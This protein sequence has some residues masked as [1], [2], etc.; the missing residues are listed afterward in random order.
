M[1]VKQQAG[2]LAAFGTVA[3]ILL[4]SSGMFGEAFAATRAVHSPA[5]A[6]CATR[7]AR[8]VAA[9]PR[10]ANAA[11]TAAGR[12]VNLTSFIV[13]SVGTPTPT[14]SLPTT[15]TET[16]TSVPSSATPTAPASQSDSPSPS[17]SATSPSPSDS[18]TPTSSP[19][20]SKSP[21]PSTSPTATPTPTPTAKKAKLCVSVEP[22]ASGVRPGQTARYAIWVWTATTAA[23]K[24]SV[25]AVV[26]PLAHV[27]AAKFTVCP[28]VQDKACKIGNL[29][30]GQADELQ[31]T[32]KAAD[33]VT[34]GK[35]VKLT[36]TATGKSA[37]SFH[38]AASVLI[39]KKPQAT[40]TLTPSAPTIPALP[41]PVLPG[42]IAPTLP[43][44]AATNPVNL[45]PTVSPG[46]GTPAPSTGP[47]PIT[48]TRPVNAIPASATVPLNPRL[49]GGQLAGLAVLAGAVVIAIAR[50]SLRAQKPQGS[51]A[52]D[53]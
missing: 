51:K 6:L 22:F 5:S 18:S 50:L 43:G 53:D 24:V 21:S 2:R 29:P 10:R 19:T 16:P 7:P 20:T 48:K 30:V 52:A 31:A 34:V 27:G 35:K 47:T 1:P 25:S 38:A 17:D 33:A 42:G 28:V 12:P 14:P 44:T 40:P 39:T 32:V 41:T 45:F 46:T 11:R 9:T 15:P 49:I 8:T 3:G 26:G 13:V 37:V 23:T 4:I 36:A